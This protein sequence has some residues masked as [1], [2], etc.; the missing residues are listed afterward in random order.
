MKECQ[1]KGQPVVARLSHSKQLLTRRTS[2]ARQTQ[3]QQSSFH[4]ATTHLYPSDPPGVVSAGSGI[5]AR[6]SAGHKPSD[7]DADLVSPLVMYSAQAGHV[8][9]AAAPLA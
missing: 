9:N 8:I 4:V 1:V 3:L 6:A 5:P 2:L 7:S